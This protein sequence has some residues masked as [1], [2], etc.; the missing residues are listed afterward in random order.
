MWAVSFTARPLYPWDRIGDLVGYRA[1][2]G[3][4][5]DRKS[6]AP[7]GSRKIVTQSVVHRYT[8]RA[9][10]ACIQPEQYQP[11][12]SPS[13]ISRYTA[14][15]ISAGI[16]PEQYQPVYSL[17]NISRYTARTVSAGIQPEQYQPVYSP[18]HISSHAACRFFSGRDWNVTGYDVDAF[19]L[20]LNKGGTY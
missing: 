2:M 19:T 7:A 20:N 18:S 13:N 15:A 17:S 1:Y 16:Q 6:L 11:V 8:A 14:W 3:A 10:S 4:V 9:I 5:K 12:Y